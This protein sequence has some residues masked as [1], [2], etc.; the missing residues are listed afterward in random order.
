MIT[1]YVKGK[2]YF[3]DVKN[4]I[5]SF[6]YL[7]KNKK[8]KNLI[9]GGGINGIIT[10]YYF[11]KNKMLDT[12]I[13][14]ISRLGYSNTS[15]ATA[16]LEYQLDDHANDLKK[17]FTKEDI[18]SAYNVGLSSLKHI[19][20]IINTLGNSCEYS[21][22]D[23]LMYTQ[24]KSE[25]KE[26]V[27]E[28]EF[29]L[30]N[31]FDVSFIT[32]KN[33]PYPFYIE[34]GILAKNGGAEFNPYLF[35]KILVDNISKDINIYENTEATKII[36]TNKGFRVIT[37]YGI[38][39]ECENIICSTG[40]NTKLFTEKKLCEKLI[41][42]TIVTTPLKKPL[43]KNREL[44]QDNSDPY[45]YMRLSNDNRLILGGE[46]I[47]FKNSTIKEKVAKKKYQKLF[48]YAKILFPKEM[49]NA[50]IDYEF[51]GAFSSTTNN[52]SLVGEL[53]TPHIYYNLGY[54]ANG[55]IYSIY[56]AQSIVSMINGNTMDLYNLFTP[57]RKLP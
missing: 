5:K 41:S 50:K 31:G 9:I 26:L 24:K 13:I 1:K 51:C 25:K 4:K 48:D 17:Y 34:A 15:C 39:I 55:I 18:V 20:D 44:L 42:Y 23:T 3:A 33:N 45:H 47:P 46:D 57:N 38:E 21:V 56:G 6:P 30:Q 11:H 19:D 53:E 28:F 12:I 7:T 40:Y 27:R 29:R 49:K 35:E 54:G 8:C 36:K 16:L 14:D 32:P 2:P 22:R 52:L 10:A 43:W 37:N